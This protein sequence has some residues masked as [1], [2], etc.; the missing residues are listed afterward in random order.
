[1]RLHVPGLPHTEVTPDYSWCAF[2]QNLRLWVNMM[3]S[4]GHEVTVYAPGEGDH[5]G[6]HISLGQPTETRSFDPADWAD[7]NR[8]VIEA[9]DGDGMLCLIGGLCQQQIAQA[10]DLPTVEYAVGYG[11]RF[12][13][14]AC[15]PSYAWMHTVY[16]QAGAHDADGLFYDTVIP[17]Y[18]DPDQ[19]DYIND[20]DDY[21]LYVG[22]LEQRKGLDIV[23]DIAKHTDRRVIVAGS[24]PYPVP[25]GCEYAGPVGP[26]E[27]SKLMGHAHAL[28]APTLYLE[29]FGLVAIEAMTCGTPVISTD[30]GGFVETVSDVSGARCRTMRQFLDATEQDF[31]RP[32]VRDWSERFWVDSIAPRYDDWLGDVQTVV[33]GRGF[34]QDVD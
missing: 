27:R 5:A 24:G 13:P 6:T 22:R 19:F 12:A 29:P 33:T 11:G 18:V 34:Y 31:C 8:S 30:W 17:H 3:V 21:L 7:L 25:E 15:F 4:Q 14:Y 32:E 23:G 20:P 9:V 28:L 26:A 1:M 2:T 16:G 10:L